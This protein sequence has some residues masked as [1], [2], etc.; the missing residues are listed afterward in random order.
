MLFSAG[1]K[2]AVEH[3]FVNKSNLFTNKHLVETGNIYIND[4]MHVTSHVCSKGWGW[5]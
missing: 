5:G 3:I 2:K 4:K 1:V